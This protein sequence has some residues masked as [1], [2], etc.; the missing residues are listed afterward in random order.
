MSD[1]S[2]MRDRVRERPVLIEEPKPQYP[3]CPCPT[4][5]DVRF[6]H[7]SEADTYTAHDMAD[8]YMRGY[9]RGVESCDE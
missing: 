5:H 4:C 1:Q 3:H 2:S 6:G 9:D 7:F 8:A